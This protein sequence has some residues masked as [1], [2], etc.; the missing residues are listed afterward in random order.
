MRK[1]VLKPHRLRGAEI[2]EGRALLAVAAV[3]TVSI[4]DASVIE[5]NSGT[6]NLSFV[7][8]LSFTS[9]QTTTVQFQTRDGT[10]TAADVDYLAASGT[11]TFRPGQRTAMVTVPVRGDT[12]IEQDETFQVVLANPTNATLGRSTAVGAILDDDAAPRTVTVA[13]PVVAVNEGSPVTFTFT[14]SRPASAAVSVSYATRDA[15]AAAGSDYSAA[16]GTFSFAIGE[17]TKTVVVPTL[18][19][20]VVESAETFQMRVTSV[21]G[22]VIGIESVANATIADVPPVTPPPPA[23]G[24]WTILVYMTGE[25]LN[26]DAKNDI[27]EMEKFLVGAPAG[28]S[29]VVSWDQPKSSVGTAYATGGG[30]QSAWRTYGRSVLKADSSTTSIASTFDLSFGEKN[31]GA[32][33]TLVDFVKWGV[34]KAPAQHYV[35]QMWGHGGGLDGSQFDSESGSD[36]LTIGEMGTALATAGMPTFDIV[37][38]DNCLMQMAEVSA[39]IVP[40]LAAGGA[41]V[42]SEESINGSG[43]DYTTAYSA[44]KVADPTAVTVSQIVAGMTT[45]YWNQYKTD[46]IYD[47]FSGTLASASAALTDAI[48]QFVD[49]TVGLSSPNRTTILNAAKAATGFDVT[50]FRDLGK[51]MTGVAAATSLPQTVRDAA[52]GVRSAI[53]AAVSSKTPDARG[54]TGISIFLPTTSTDGYLPSYATDAAVFC[55]AT[56]WNSFANWLATG[57]RA[58]LTAT[59]FSGTTTGHHAHRNLQAAAIQAAAFRGFGDATGHNLVGQS[60]ARHRVRAWA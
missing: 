36:A 28:V 31:T 12:N 38:Y 45:S 42:A 30:T 11:L 51:F 9:S 1:L 57:T 10:A 8:S 50:S 2:L 33:A 19:D 6:R 22:A 25:N 27:N 20:A 52:T 4:A 32:P 13:G 49:S 60:G 26:T 24:S 18:T 53:T 44:L 3:P 35:L 43:Q 23:T 7:A 21:T 54:T 39:A 14:L 17:T 55:Q 59:T 34:Q 47:T 46:G 16:I 15:T 56:G 48:K 41:F 40:N 58:A 29:I 37:S 5:G